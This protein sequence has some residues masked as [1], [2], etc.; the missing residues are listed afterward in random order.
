MSR[1][2]PPLTSAKADV[3]VWQPGGQP[4]GGL[5]QLVIHWLIEFDRATKDCIDHTST[6]YFPQEVHGIVTLH[7]I[8]TFKWSGRERQ[9]RR[10]MMGFQPS[11]SAGRGLQRTEVVVQCSVPLPLVEKEMLMVGHILWHEPFHFSISCF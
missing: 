4:G 5:R 3:W 8:N 1:S 9:S 2:P 7:V 6:I 11:S 10:R